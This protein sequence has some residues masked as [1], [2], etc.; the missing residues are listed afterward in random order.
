M[1]STVIAAYLER[2]EVLD[3]V[4]ESSVTRNS[5]VGRWLPV[6]EHIIYAVQRVVGL[7]EGIL[8]VQTSGFIGWMSYEGLKEQR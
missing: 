3:E 1:G 5:D 6:V 8:A 7:S 4:A 2:L